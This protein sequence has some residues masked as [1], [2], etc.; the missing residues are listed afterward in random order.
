[1]PEHEYPVADLPTPSETD[2]PSDAVALQL[3]A[4]GTNDDPFENAGIMTAYNFASPANRRSTGPLDRF[5]AMVESPQYCPMIDF[6]EAVRGPVERTENYAEQRVTITGPNG[7]TT[8][9]EFGLSVQSVGEF[10]GCWQT[11]RV[12]VV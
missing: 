8:T 4:L 7:R 3:D 12:V 9:Y 10:R 5:I 6:G 2:S 11:D 1:M